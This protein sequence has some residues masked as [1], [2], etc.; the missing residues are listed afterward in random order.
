MQRRSLMTKQHSEQFLLIRNLDAAIRY[1]IE[2]NLMMTCEIKNVKITLVCSNNLDLEI[3]TKTKVLFHK[4]KCCFLKR[5]FCFRKRKFCVRK[6]K[7][8]SGNETFV[9]EKQS[10]FY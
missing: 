1:K 6:R 7:F 4:T 10:L 2:A 3:Q 9:S 5:K 8:V